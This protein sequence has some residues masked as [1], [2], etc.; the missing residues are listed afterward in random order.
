MCS[1][2]PG[3]LLLVAMAASRAFIDTAAT[4]YSD[5]GIS[6]PATMLRDLQVG[7]DFSSLN[8]LLSEVSL[9]LPDTTISISTLG[10]VVRL[11]L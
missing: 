9:V 11:T 5:G 6:P 10:R 1:T 7:G 4:S 2:A 8:A 3:K